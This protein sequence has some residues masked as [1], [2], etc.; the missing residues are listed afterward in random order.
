VRRARSLGINISEA[1]ET[2]LEERILEAER[3]SWLESN[4]EGITGYNER[5]AQEGALSDGWRSF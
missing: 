3:E 1:L 4:Q 2:A 5:I